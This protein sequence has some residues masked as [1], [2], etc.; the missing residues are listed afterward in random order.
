MDLVVI[1]NC[2]CGDTLISFTPWLSKLDNY[3]VSV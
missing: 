1:I 3:L 2:L